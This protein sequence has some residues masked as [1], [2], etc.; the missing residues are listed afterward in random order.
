MRFGGIGDDAVS[1]DFFGC[2]MIFDLCFMGCLMSFAPFLD[3]RAHLLG[4][5]ARA[6]LGPLYNPLPF[7]FVFGLTS[8]AP[9]TRLTEISA[10]P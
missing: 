9:S 5:G 2:S 8:I 6:V 1:C 3:W 4:I 10:E 7:L